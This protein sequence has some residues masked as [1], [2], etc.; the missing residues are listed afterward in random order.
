MKPMGDVVPSVVSQLTGE[1]MPGEMR[2]RDVAFLRTCAGQVRRQDVRVALQLERVAE[3][4]ER[5]IR[6]GQL[7][8]VTD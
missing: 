3:R 6:A 2:D 5:A 1:P 8:P 4:L 7:I